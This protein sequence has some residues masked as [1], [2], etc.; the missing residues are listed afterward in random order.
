[1]NKEFN[2]ELKTNKNN[3]YLITFSL[4]SVLGIEANQI[5]DLI[6]KSFSNE[7]TFDEIIEKNNFFKENNSLEEAFD[8][9]NFRITEEKKTTIEE[10]ENNLKIKIPVP[11]RLNKEIIFTL[12]QNNK[13][14]NE[15]INDLAQLINKQNQEITNLKEED[16][17]LK[18]EITELKNENIQL[19]NEINEL[20]KDINDI[21]VRFNIFSKSK[22]ERQTID[23]LN[24]KIINENEEYYNMNLKRW[25]NPTKNLKA[26]LLY[27][28]SEN[29]EKYETFHQL[30]DKKGPTL[31]LFH[32]KENGY[33]VGIYTPLSWDKNYGYKK[34]ME[35][36]IFNLNKE[37]KFKKLKPE[38]SIAQQ[39]DYVGPITEYFGCYKRDKYDS[40]KFMYCGD[41]NNDICNNNNELCNNMNNNC[42][43]MNNCNNNN[44]LCNNINNNC[45]YM[46]NCYS[47]NNQYSLDDYYENGHDI[48]PITIGYKKYELIEVEVFKIIIE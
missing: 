15:K 20:K 18:N 6:K 36:F 16:T 9:L 11:N 43:Y 35:T 48:L 24:S 12:K 47:N 25:I 7:F 21:K 17:K 37:Q 3:T 29:G 13:N 8:E 42:N 40:M 32:I 41:Y 19:K 33:K 23:N 46:N 39:S 5:N 34:D 1:M 10:S 30:C 45:N 4:G 26:Q 31:T 28:L 27:R 14:E 2:I 22:G 38:N 44:E